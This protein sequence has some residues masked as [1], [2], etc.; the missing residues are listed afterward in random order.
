MEK[1]NRTAWRLAAILAVVVLGGIGLLAFQVGRDYL[2]QRALVDA[3]KRGDARAVEALLDQGVSVKARG[4]TLSA[5]EY[6]I[7][8]GDTR[9]VNAFLAHGANVQAP[10]P[11]GSTPLAFAVRCRQPAMVKVLLARGAD[12]NARDGIIGMTPLMWA[13]GDGRTE[14]VRALIEH[15]ADVDAMSETGVTPLIAAVSGRRTAVV[16]LLLAHGVDVNAKLTDTGS[17]A[18][19][20]TFTALALARENSRAARK[21]GMLDYVSDYEAIIRL[22]QEA[23]AKE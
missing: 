7:Q 15:G 6:A 22:L 11:S 2:Q 12:P 23:G 9:I 16:K 17:G 14:I 19:N 4:E 20:Q 8:S 21:Q 3:A 10:S 18:P 1:T 13:A 5:F